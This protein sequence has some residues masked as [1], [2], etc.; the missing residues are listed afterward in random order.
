MEDSEVNIKNRLGSYIIMCRRIIIIIIGGQWSC[1][2]NDI[3]LHSIMILS[4]AGSGLG[5]GSAPRVQ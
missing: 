2:E 5:D 1:I 4:S 3:L